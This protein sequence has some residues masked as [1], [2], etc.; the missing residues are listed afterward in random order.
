[1]K[2]AVLINAYPINEK[3]QQILERS[4]K[5]FKKLGL[6][7][8]VVSGCDIPIHISKDIDYYIINR[9]K[10]VLNKSY[11]KTCNDLL[12][13][14]NDLACLTFQ[15]NN[16]Q[17]WVYYSNHNVTIA[18]NT[19]M[20]FEFAKSIG[21]ENVF[22]TEDDNVFNESSFDSINQHLEMLNK[23][24]GIKFISSWG[25]MV[26][27]NTPMLFSCLFFSNINFFLE[28]FKIPTTVEEWYNSENIIKYKLNRAYEESLHECFLPVKDQTHNYIS[29][30]SRLIESKSADLNL[31]SRYEDLNWRVNTTFTVLKEFN[32]SRLFFVAYNFVVTT[33]TNKEIH[34]RVVK[35]GTTIF[36]NV[37]GPY[38]WY[39]EDVT[40]ANKISF[41][42]D[43]CLVKDIDLNDIESIE[44]NG[45]IIC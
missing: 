39:C 18:R 7:I 41:Y 37:M 9:E 44:N 5:N 23:N 45:T 26:D 38:C 6:P 43:G 17:A 29:E 13:K 19:K 40:N 25:T 20:V 14:S 42:V 10:L 3:K 12:G 31:T 36:D 33:S 16:L 24:D 27:S 35:D 28:H 4:V 30:Y 1:M 8:I 15:M 11:L 32:G 2:N 21:F 34:L 22:Y